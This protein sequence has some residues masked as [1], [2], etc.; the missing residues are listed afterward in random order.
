MKKYIKIEDLSVQENRILEWRLS[1]SPN[2]KKKY[3]L[4]PNVYVEYD[5]NIDKVPKSILVIPALSGVVMLSWHIGADV[6]VEELDETY[7]NA[8]EKIKKVMKSWWPNLPF[9]EIYVEKIVSNK[10]SN[11]GYGM[12]FSSGIDSMVTYIRH[13]EKKPNLIH[14]VTRG[15]HLK[16]NK[17]HLINFAN[18]E[19]V[20][21]NIIRT[22]INDSL[23]ERLL[24]A[25]FG[26][27]WWGNISHSIIYTGLSAPL[28]IQNKIGTLLIASSHTREFKHPWGSHPLIDNNISWGGGKSYA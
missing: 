25:Q 7:L 9:S 18:E 6:Y 28:T 20:T 27:A 2:V 17:E 26:V 8:L 22:N 13:R 11:K 15:Q 3:L 16:T 21:I 4:T 23:H 1:S 14:C 12:L 24:S 10:V 5:Q 19:N